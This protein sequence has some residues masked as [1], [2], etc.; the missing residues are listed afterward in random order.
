MG[1]HVVLGQMERPSR[2]MAKYFGIPLT[3]R[4]TSAGAMRSVRANTNQLVLG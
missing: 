3:D 2:L 1:A 4:A